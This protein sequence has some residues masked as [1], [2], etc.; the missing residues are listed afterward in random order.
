MTILSESIVPDG[1]DVL[2]ELDLG[3]THTF[4][5]RQKPDDVQTAVENAWLPTD[6]FGE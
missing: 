2:V 4:H 3:G 5:F 1:Y 6:D